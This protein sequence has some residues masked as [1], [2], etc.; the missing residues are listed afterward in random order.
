MSNFQVRDPGDAWPWAQL[1]QLLSSSWVPYPWSRAQSVGPDLLGPTPSAA[2]HGGRLRD[3]ANLGETPVGYSAHPGP[4]ADYSAFRV[5]TTLFITAKGVLSNMNQIADIRQAPEK[6]YP[7]FFDFLLYSPA[8]VL[9][10]IREFNFTVMVGFPADEENVVIRDSL[11]KHEVKISEAPGTLKS[12]AK[13]LD[14]AH[15]EQGGFGMGQTLD[16]AITA[17]IAHAPPPRSSTADAVFTYKILESGKMVG[18]FAG[19]N[20]FYALVSSGSP[21]P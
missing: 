10:T 18:G 13:L 20:L 2:S 4:A 1:L 3:G 7:P 19:I 9:P 21:T 16:E 5:G 8:I 11:G 17:A 14:F 12:M 15:S 6:I